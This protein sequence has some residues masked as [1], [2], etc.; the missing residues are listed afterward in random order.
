MSR[1]FW[2]GWSICKAQ[3]FYS[4][5]LRWDNIIHRRGWKQQVSQKHEKQDK[6]NWCEK[7]EYKRFNFVHTGTH[8]HKRVRDPVIKPKF[9]CLMHSKAKQTK[10][11]ESGAE[12]LTAGS[13]NES[14]QFM[15]QR[16]KLSHDFDRRVFIGEIWGRDAGV[17]LSS[18]WLVVR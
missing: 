3:R 15:L 18:D 17:G 13:G 1:F 8:I 10:M 9:T 7:G 16:L 5:W 6:L 4:L 12:R 14:R 2:I 11:L